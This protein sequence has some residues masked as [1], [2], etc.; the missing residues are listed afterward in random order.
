MIPD[1]MLP[2][3]DYSCSDDDSE[4]KSAVVKNPNRPHVEYCESSSSSE[5][6]ITEL[7]E[8]SDIIK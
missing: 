5:E 3:S 4:T 2:S 8:S 7:A 6:D 1:D